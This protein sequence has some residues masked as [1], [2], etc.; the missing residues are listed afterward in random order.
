VF[1]SSQDFAS[2]RAAWKAHEPARYAYTFR[3]TCFC[4][5]ES[6]QVVASRDSV[7]QARNFRSLQP[8]VVEDVYAPQHYSIDSLF[9]ALEAMRATHPYKLRVTF[10]AEYGFP[11]TVDYDGD[12]NAEDDEYYVVIS[13][14]HPELAP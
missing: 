1:D 12:K 13:G 4:P 11:E 5:P 3:T 2:A 7:L 9:A 8:G 6:V 14:F 10:D